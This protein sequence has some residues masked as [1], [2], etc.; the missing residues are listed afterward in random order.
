ML[1]EG[2]QQR[3]TRPSAGS[4]N[5]PVRLTFWNMV[6][7][8][9]AVLA[10]KEW[11]EDYKS[12]KSKQPIQL[13]P[14][15][16]EA[17]ESLL[18]RS[19]AVHGAHAVGALAL[20]PANVEEP[21]RR[22]RG[23]CVCCGVRCDLICKALG[24]VVLIYALI[25]GYKFIKWIVTPEPTGLENMPAFSSSL[26][27]TKGKYFFGPDHSKDGVSYTIPLQG[28]TPVLRVNFD[29]AAAGTVVLTQ[30]ETDTEAEV[31]LKLRTN[32]EPL[33]TDVS[34][35]SSSSSWQ[36]KTPSGR[37]ANDDACMRF[38][39]VLAVPKTLRN[40]TLVST[41]I[42][43]VQFA[44]G[45][46]F[47]LHS[48]DVSLHSRSALNMLLPHADISAEHAAIELHG[49]Y[50]VGTL[51]LRGSANI[52]TKRG[53]TITK[54]TLAADGKPDAAPQLTTA[55]GSARGDFTYVN[56]DARPINAEHT[57]TGGDLYLRYAS[58]AFSG[59]IDIEA[60]SW[61]A[62]GGVENFGM[63]NPH[64]KPYVGDEKGTDRLKIRTSGWVGTYF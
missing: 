42:L 39:A 24:I 34:A 1:N 62:K 14:D 28:S 15:D 20:D 29:G 32:Q 53:D 17:G 5:G 19:A 43:Q 9:T 46:S 7:A 45:S 37:T 18:A 33:L 61:T 48:L 12:G 63:H 64:G 38:D 25:G 60:K 30:G 10:V 57:S 35:T 11:Y 2:L 27:C 6:M 41:S 26:G 47:Q 49:G 44:Q 52:N 59:P 55:T 4:S 40:L 22:R 50:L 3:N 13:Q 58:S 21:Y 51:A 56:A 8:T 54:L 16:A 36:L 31:T 23:W